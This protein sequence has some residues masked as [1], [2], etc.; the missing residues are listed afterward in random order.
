MANESGGNNPTANPQ[1][2]TPSQ[3]PMIP[4]APGKS[5]ISSDPNS[6]RNDQQSTAREL[7]REFRWVEVGTFIV[8][9]VLAIIGIIA[10]CIYRGQLTTMQG[11]LGQMQTSSDQTDKLICLYRQ[12]VA[13]LH[14]QAADTHGLADAAKKQADRMAEQIP[15]LKKSAKAAQDA[16]R[17]A[18]DTLHISERAY[19]TEGTPQ[20]DTAKTVVTIP[21][22]NSGHIPSGKID[23]VV[24][25][26]TFNPGTVTTSGGTAFNSIVERHKSINHISAIAPGLP[27]NIGVPAPQMSADLLNKGTQMVAVVGTITYNDGFPD[28]PTQHSTICINTV[29]HLVAKESYLVPCDAGADLPKFESLDWTGFTSNYP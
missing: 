28:S 16:A 6:G 1:G 13:E 23:V 19:V 2:Q 22:V 25:E 4:S 5:E 12:Q 21:I 9:G 26:A 15:E 8:N 3:S 29:Y 17:V 27:I 18:Q 14:K 11:Q 20:I 7:A 24:Y 10:L